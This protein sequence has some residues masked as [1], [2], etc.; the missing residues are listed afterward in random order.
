MSKTILITGA[1]SDIGVS[2]I[3][4][5]ADDYDHILAHYAHRADKLL[6]LR[7]ELGDKLLL[8]QA[9]FSEEASVYGMI[10]KIQKDGLTPT[11][12]LHLPAERFELQ[13]FHKLGWDVFQSGLNISLRSVVLLAQAFLPAMKKARSGKLLIMLSS[14]VTSKAPK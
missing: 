12:I 6:A 9:D 10:D 4:R 7:E 2:L 14:T 8:L 13:R 5:V 11:H 3:R 1:S